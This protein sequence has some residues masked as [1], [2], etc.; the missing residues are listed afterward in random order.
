[1]K[2]VVVVFDRLLFFMLESVDLMKS[3]FVNCYNF[4]VPNAII[5]QLYI[6]VVFCERVQMRAGSKETVVCA[7]RYEGRKFRLFAI[8]LLFFVVCCFAGVT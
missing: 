4:V 5:T 8:I 1:M 6:F 2:L 3:C 7:R